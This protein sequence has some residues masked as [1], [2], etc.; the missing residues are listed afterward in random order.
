MQFILNIGLKIARTGRENTVSQTVQALERAGFAIEAIAVHQSNTERTVVAQVSIPPS[1]PVADW[2][3]VYGVSCQLGQEA[4]GVWSPAI[5]A[6]ALV[7]PDCESWGDFNPAF[8]IMP[9]GNTLS[10]QT[11]PAPAAV[12]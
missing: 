2:P 12:I 1:L 9:G 5:G 3:S 11:A 8:F 6:G 7:G 4:I 10:A